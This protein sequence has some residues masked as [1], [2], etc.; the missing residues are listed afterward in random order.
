MMELEPRT[1]ESIPY[2]NRFLLDTGHTRM[3]SQAAES[4]VNGL[5][6]VILLDKVTS[7]SNITRGR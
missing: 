1:D 6:N 5:Q 2:M 4:N 3:T 7:E